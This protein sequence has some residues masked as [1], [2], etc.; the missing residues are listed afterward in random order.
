MSSP[1]TVNDTHLSPALSGHTHTTSWDS[2]S[3]TVNTGMSPQYLYDP[4]PRFVRA[5]QGPPQEIDG[6]ADNVGLGLHHVRQ[7]SRP[8]AELGG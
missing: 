1:R 7:T 4:P 3:A 5:H 6:H 2:N 8:R